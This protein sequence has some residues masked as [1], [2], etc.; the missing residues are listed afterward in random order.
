MHL[1]PIRYRMAL[2]PEWHYE[3][4]AQIA[5]NRWKIEEASNPMIYDFPEIAYIHLEIAE[6]EQRISF[7]AFN[8][9]VAIYRKFLNSALS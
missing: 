1:L 3:M 8:L 6:S 4:E 7:S 9:C 2:N 5:I